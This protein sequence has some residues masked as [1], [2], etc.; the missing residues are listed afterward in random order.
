MWGRAGHSIFPSSPPRRE[1][2]DPSQCRVTKFHFIFKLTFEIRKEGRLV[3]SK[4]ENKDLCYRKHFIFLSFSLDTA[5]LS[6]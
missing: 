3:G 1:R 2:T 5:D 6:C 4:A